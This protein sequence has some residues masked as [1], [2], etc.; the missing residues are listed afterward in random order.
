[1][2]ISNN[3]FDENNDKIY[4][5]ILDYS[6]YEKLSQDFHNKDNLEADFV[7]FIEK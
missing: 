1:M 4:E 5:Y 2:R 3:N 6:N 7:K